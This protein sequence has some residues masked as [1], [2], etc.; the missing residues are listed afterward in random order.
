VLAPY[1]VKGLHSSAL[2]ATLRRLIVNN[3][4]REGTQLAY[5]ERAV[6]EGYE[7]VVLN[8]NLNRFPDV[9]RTG[10]SK[11]RHVPV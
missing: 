1:N 6:E 7:V 11:H 2:V 5:V 4:L 10:S 9:S 3:G 8:T